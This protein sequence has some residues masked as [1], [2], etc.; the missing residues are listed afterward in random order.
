VTPFTRC[1]EKSVA[2]EP[3]G[4][5][6]MTNAPQNHPR[7]V[8]APVPGRHRPP[9]L[10]PS[11][12]GPVIGHQPVAPA[13]RQ[14]PPSGPPAGA[15]MQRQRPPTMAPRPTTAPRPM[16]APAHRGP[17]PVGRPRPHPTAERPVPVNRRPV[18]IG[19]RSMAA[20]GVLS[21]YLIRTASVLGI[22]AVLG[23]ASVAGE[24]QT[25]TEGA[26]ASATQHGSAGR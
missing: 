1:N 22:L 19:R 8:V 20:V 10:G 23:V 24:Q 13:Q 3:I 11:A 4:V 7:P 17:V 16:M 25:P 18:P 5:S 9:T 21:D 26:T 15:P 2:H 12:M 6:A 14:G